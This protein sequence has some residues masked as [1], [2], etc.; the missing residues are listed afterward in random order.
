MLVREGLTR[1]TALTLLLCT[2]LAFSQ[3]IVRHYNLSPSGQQTKRLRLP[4]GAWQR[5]VSFVRARQQQQHSEQ[6]QQQQQQDKTPGSNVAAALAAEAAYTH[7]GVASASKVKEANGRREGA[8]HGHSDTSRQPD[9][10]PGVAAGSETSSSSSSLPDSSSSSSSS[11]DTGLS[12]GSVSADAEHPGLG[13]F[14]APVPHGSSSSSSSDQGEGG[15]PAGVL[16]M[17]L[18]VDGIKCEGCA[19]RLKA[20]LLAHPG[21][22]R[23]AVDYGAREVR[24][25]G[26]AGRVSEAGVVGAVQWVDLGYRVTVLESGLVAGEEAGDGWR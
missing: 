15:G 5:L 8:T 9:Q 4:S 19:A 21:V 23:A 14:Q 11:P 3:D 6:Q 26:D 25:W 13:P 16:Y 18:R 10:G 12:G 17:R 22:G 2:S 24:L 7:S 1:R 20:A